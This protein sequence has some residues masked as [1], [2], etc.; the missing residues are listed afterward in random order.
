MTLQHGL[1]AVFCFDGCFR[2]PKSAKFQRYLVL[3][4]GFYHARAVVSQ[5]LRKTKPRSNIKIFSRQNRFKAIRNNKHTITWFVGLYFFVGFLNHYR[6]PISAIY[7]TTMQLIQLA[8]QI[9]THFICR[10]LMYDRIRVNDPKNVF[11]TGSQFRF[12]QEDG[13][14][15]YHTYQV[16]PAG[17]N[18]I[19]ICTWY[20]IV[21]YLLLQYQYMHVVYMAL[22]MLNC[23]HDISRYIR[24]I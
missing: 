14:Q 5:K 16:V 2:K 13:I 12:T 22:Y 17:T 8:S 20:V 1:S 24:G 10:R 23:N 19:H 9:F 21:R 3:R 11:F 4:V 6:C 7:S 15:Y 18:S